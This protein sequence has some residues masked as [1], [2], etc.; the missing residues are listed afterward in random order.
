MNNHK[1]MRNISVISRCAT[2]YREERISKYGLTG[3]QAPY[4][5]LVCTNPSI[6]P[7]EI[8]DKLHVNKS[9]VTRVIEKLEKKGFVKQVRCDDDKRVIHI[10]PTPKAEEIVDYVRGTFRDWRELLTEGLDDNQL[11][12]IEQL[13][14][15]LAKRAIEINENDI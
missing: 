7:K 4:I 15:L 6:T 13:T 8:S 9:T 5:S 14:E 2:S 3:N 1:F 11:E 12:M 10:H